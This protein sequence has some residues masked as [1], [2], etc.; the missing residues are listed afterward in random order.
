MAVIE[1]HSLIVNPTVQQ[2]LLNYTEAI[3]TGLPTYAAECKVSK[4]V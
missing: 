4:Q 1:A 2:D 3:C